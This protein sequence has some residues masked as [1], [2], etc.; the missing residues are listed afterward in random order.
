MLRK[1]PRQKN[2]MQDKSAHFFVT[3]V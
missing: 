2:D 1:N 3:L